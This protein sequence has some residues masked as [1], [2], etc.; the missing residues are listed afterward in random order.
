MSMQLRKQMKMTNLMEK[1]NTRRKRRKSL[2]LCLQTSRRR[3]TWKM[4][5]KN[6]ARKTMRKGKNRLSR[7]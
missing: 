3:S 2:S 6:W 5:Q 1:L 4:K 7:E